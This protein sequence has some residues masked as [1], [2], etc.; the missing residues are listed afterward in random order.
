ME[1]LIHT[2]SKGKAVELVSE[3]VLIQSEQDALDL[4]ANC[5]YHYDS[6][7][8]IIHKEN[9][10]ESF[11]ELKSGLAGAVLQKFVNYKVQLAIIGDFSS[12]NSK[13]LNDFIYECNQGNHIFFLP[14]IQSSLERFG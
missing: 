10:S 5:E 9:I 12:Y 8:I 3:E 4:M 11:F 14:D 7:R 2:I 6:R 1:N 13:S